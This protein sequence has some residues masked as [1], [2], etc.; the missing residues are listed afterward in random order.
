[1]V[2][3]AETV[4]WTHE[5]AVHHVAGLSLGV[6]AAIISLEHGPLE[7]GDV[8]RALRDWESLARRGL[9][10]RPGSNPCGIPQC[11]G[12]GPRGVL[13]EAIRYLPRRAKPGL[14]RVVR[15]IDELYLS[16]TLP[17]PLADLGSPWWERRRPAGWPRPRWS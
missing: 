3:R 14:R 12:P 9:V 5:Q 8:A 4:C 16:R 17:D 6:V 7:P 10:Y 11:C 15:Q 1:M 2:R 13:E